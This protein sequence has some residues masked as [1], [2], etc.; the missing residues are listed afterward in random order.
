MGIK[1]MDRIIKTKKQGFVMW[2]LPFCALSAI[3]LIMLFISAAYVFVSYFLLSLSAVA[4]FINYSN[5][6]KYKLTAESM[7]ELLEQLTDSDIVAGDIYMIDHNNSRLIV[8]LG[9]Y[10]LGDLSVCRL[11]EIK[12]VR[13]GFEFG[14]G[15][16]SST[17]R[18]IPMLIKLTSGKKMRMYCFVERTLVK[19]ARNTL[20][21]FFKEYT[22][23]E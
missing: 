6:H 12:S 4:V 8:S 20:N 1:I 21:E 13:L 5:Y 16:G 18:F 3:A 11:D 22:G 7:E 2:L 14:I 23:K 10:P 17:H 19:Q 9:E 15:N